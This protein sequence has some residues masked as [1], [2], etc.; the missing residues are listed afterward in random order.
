[1]ATQSQHHIVKEPIPAEA[2]EVREYDRPEDAEL[3]RAMVNAI[4]AAESVG[5]D[6]LTRL[7]AIELASHYYETR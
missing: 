2:P 3:D 5:N 4:E 7:L 1:M 6:F